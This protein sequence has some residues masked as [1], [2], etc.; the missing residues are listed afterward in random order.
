[1]SPGCLQIYNTYLEVPLSEKNSLNGFEL[2]GRKTKLKKINCN[3]LPLIH[4]FY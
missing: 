1:M 4:V 3:N 2:I